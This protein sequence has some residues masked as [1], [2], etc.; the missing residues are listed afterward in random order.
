MKYY[1]VS[2]DELFDLVH[3]TIANGEATR[4]MF[5]TTREEFQRRWEQAKAACRARPV[6]RGEFD[7]MGHTIYAWEEIKR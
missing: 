6:T 7:G 4:S 1:V 3:A 2:E 5:S